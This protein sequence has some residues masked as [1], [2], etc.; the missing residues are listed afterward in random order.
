MK[1]G[2]KK[3]YI[4]RGETFDDFLANDGILGDT[5]DAAIKEIIA[6]QIKAAMARQKLTKTQMAVRMKTSRR[7]LDRLLDPD[8]PSVT[9]ST[10]RRAAS[11]VGRNLRVELE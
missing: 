1:K 6:D 3:G 10:L 9:L 8:N 2:R 4:D 11:A 5:E 7:Q